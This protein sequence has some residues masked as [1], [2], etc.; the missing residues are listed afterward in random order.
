MARAFDDSE[1][2][3]V[4]NALIDAGEKLFGQL[5][6]TKTAVED[7]TRE[8][9]VAKGTFYTFWPSKEAFFFA[10]LE[11]VEIRYQKEVINPIFESAAHPAEALGRLITEA[12]SQ[13]DEYPLIRAALDVNL[14]RRL[15]R[16][17][18]PET[19]EEHQRTDRNEFRTITESWNP[20]VFDPGISPEVLDGMF[21]GLLMM[22]LHRDI[23]G[24]DIYEEVTSCMADVMSA[25]LKALSDKRIDRRNGGRRKR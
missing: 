13:L 5:G 9:G 1:K 25:G 6:F 3:A 21:K 2:T 24:E 19:L 20:Q 7:I 18:P 22:S 10:C 12:F 16:K 23:I 11:R 15:S 17:L 8:A 14:I 4:T